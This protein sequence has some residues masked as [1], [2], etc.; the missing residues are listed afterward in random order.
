[1][2]LLRCS[3]LLG[4]IA[5]LNS[6]GLLPAADSTIRLFN[7]KNLDG[8]DIFL[9]SKGLNN[10]PEHVFRVKDGMLH[11]SGAE[12]GYII[13][14]Q[15]YSN[16]RL[17]AEFRWGEE[18]HP[19]RLGQARDNGILFHVAGPNQIWPASIEFQII[20]GGTGDIILVGDTTLT[21][22]GV[23][24]TKAR[25][26]RLGKS[27]LPERSLYVSGYRDPRLEYEKPHGEWNV[28]E[29]FAEGDHIKYVVNGRVANEANGS[30][31]TKGRI[32]FQSEGAEA[33][34]RNIELQPL[35]GK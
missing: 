22:D 2:L 25:F 29:L 20:E 12:Y 17:R 10:D 4:A 6:G 14:R 32:L 23:T 15:E 28:L 21:R 33:W 18:T 9:E 30:S 8:F 27:P 34:F 5:L 24:R 35:P 3:V 13:T 11:I 31:R 1:V 16:Y 7:G 19:P 26:D